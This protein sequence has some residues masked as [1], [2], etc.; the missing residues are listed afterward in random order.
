[1]IVKMDA[2]AERSRQIHCATGG[3]SGTNENS[4]KLTLVAAPISGVSPV[5]CIMQLLYQDL[6]EF[7]QD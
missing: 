2:T 4:K 3:T 5:E 1:M 6:Q 7:Q